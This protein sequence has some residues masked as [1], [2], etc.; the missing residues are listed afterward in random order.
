MRILVTLLT[1]RLRSQDEQDCL[2]RRGGVGVD[3]GMVRGY[4]ED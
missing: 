1:A 2:V 4:A 3:R